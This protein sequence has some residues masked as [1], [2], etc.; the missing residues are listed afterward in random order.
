MTTL[1]E[2]SANHN[3][4]QP[5]TKAQL[6]V[7]GNGM[8]GLRAVEE[9]LACNGGQLF[10]ITVFGDEPYGNYNR[11]LLSN[12][13]AGADDTSEIYLNPIDWYTDNDVDL[14]AGVR[15]VRI[16]RFARVVQ[17]NDGT[18]M[19]YDRLIIATGSRSFFPP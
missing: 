7:I 12:V 1:L 16:D 9:I 19:R 8:A 5:T 18:A 6:V 15:V 10:D 11:I 17:A 14:R 13:L 3:G 4:R 2:P